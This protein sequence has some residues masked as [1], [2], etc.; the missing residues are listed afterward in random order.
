MVG[1][2]EV[3]GAR[4]KKEVRGSV[5]VYNYRVVYGGVL[6]VL[7]CFWI[8]ISKFFT[9][10]DDGQTQ[11]VV[12][13]RPSN[14]DIISYLPRRKFRVYAVVVMHILVR[15]SAARATVRLLGQLYQYRWVWR[16]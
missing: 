16:C 3:R 11:S 2:G 8:G 4:R 9:N 7:A 12:S 1:T 14:G 15:S 10:C 6:Y 5:L 13:I